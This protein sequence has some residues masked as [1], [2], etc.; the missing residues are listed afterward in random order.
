A[1]AVLL[2]LADGLVRVLAWLRTRHALLTLPVLFLACLPVA[3]TAHRLVVPWVRSEADRAAAL[4]LAEFCP[5]DQ[6]VTFNWEH[7]YYFRHPPVCRELVLDGF[8]DPARRLWVLAT[9]LD[10]GERARVSAQAAGGRPIL[11]R[12]E[13]PV[14]TVLLLAPA[15]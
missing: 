8:P 7:R 6:I 14:T 13:F 9:I 3:N 15:R 5:G 2:L 11:E 1:P 10:A 4:V 12:H